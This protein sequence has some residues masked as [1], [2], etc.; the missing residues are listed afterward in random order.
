MLEQYLHGVQFLF[1]YA[2]YVADGGFNLPAEHFEPRRADE[3][4]EQY[5]QRRDGVRTLK[6][7]Q[8]ATGTWAEL[9]VEECGASVHRRQRRSRLDDHSRLQAAK[10]LY[11]AGSS[12][13]GH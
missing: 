1:N 12:F 5:H 9:A 4:A 2:N 6:A 3:T 7:T 13:Q 11:L 8:A 10:E